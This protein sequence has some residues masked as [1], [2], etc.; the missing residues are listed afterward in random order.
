M[1]I[2]QAAAATGLTEKAIRLYEQQGLI[3][4]PSREIAGR[5]FRDY[6]DAA[7]TRLGQIA[8]LRRAGFTMEEIRALY[9]GQAE[10]ILPGYLE[11]QRRQIEKSRQILQALEGRTP[12]DAAEL[13][14]W[15]AGPVGQRPLPEPE[16][17]FA[18]NDALPPLP[19]GGVWLW[20]GFLPWRL[21]GGRLALALLLREKPMTWPALSAACRER[22][23]DQP[24]ERLLHLLRQLQRRGVVRE[25]DGVYTAQC[26]ALSRYDSIYTA[27]QLL[28]WIGLTQNTL[29]GRAYF[30]SAPPMSASSSAGSYGR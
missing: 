5:R 6:D 15:L 20:R 27:D 4:P 30:T 28:D 26:D 13:A 23:P 19:R 14:A 7:V 10:R 11:E 25:Q 12:R 21:H 1:R 24:P 16:C 29:G 18:A 2:K 17:R 8:T 3:E 9:D 22:L